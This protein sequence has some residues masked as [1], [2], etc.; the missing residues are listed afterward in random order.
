MSTPRKR[1]AQFSLMI[2]VLAPISITAPAPGSFRSLLYTFEQRLRPFASVPDPWGEKREA[3]TRVAAPMDG[4]GNA[5][6]YASCETIAVCLERLGDRCPLLSSLGG[7]AFRLEHEPAVLLLSVTVPY[8]HWSVVFVDQIVF[9]AAISGLMS[10]YSPRVSIV[11]IQNNRS[12]LLGQEQSNS[13]RNA[14][15]GIPDA[16][17]RFGQFSVACLRIESC[18]R[19]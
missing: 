10:F 1:D 9:Q 2:P 3:K 5:E 18:Q 13:A 4:R 19:E 6:P 16:P 14:P 12:S 7:R 8:S 11:P 17:A 15:L